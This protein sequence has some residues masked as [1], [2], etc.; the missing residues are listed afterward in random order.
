[1]LARTRKKRL[2]T[3]DLTMTLLHVKRPGTHPYCA[4]PCPGSLVDQERD[5]C[6]LCSRM[7][8]SEFLQP[9]KQISGKEHFPALVEDRK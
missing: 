4:L 9:A 6:L 1:M 2:R 7:S 3:Q 8:Q 5:P